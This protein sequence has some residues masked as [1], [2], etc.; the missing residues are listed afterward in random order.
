MRN[1]LISRDFPHQPRA[2]IRSI[3]PAAGL[4]AVLCVCCPLAAQQ[5]TSPSSEAGAGVRNS[6]APPPVVASEAI[7]TSR[8]SL[9][10]YSVMDTLEIAPRLQSEDRSHPRWIYPAVGALVGGLAGVAW[11]AYLVE[12]TPAWLAK[13]T[14]Y[15]VTVPVGAAAGALLGLIVDSR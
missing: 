2:M 3:I 4:L 11:G 1:G 12:T 5:F 7:R 10:L 6:W 15:F 9:P 13:P 8:I 14:V